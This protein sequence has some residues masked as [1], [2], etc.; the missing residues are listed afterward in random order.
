[1]QQPALMN[2]KDYTFATR[3]FLREIRNMQLDNHQESFKIKVKT[4]CFRNMD[5]R[6]LQHLLENKMKKMSPKGAYGCSGLENEMNK[7]SI[8]VS[9]PTMAHEFFPIL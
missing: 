3:E 5:S 8:F 1:M 2:N 4:A 6:K 7:Q 9:P